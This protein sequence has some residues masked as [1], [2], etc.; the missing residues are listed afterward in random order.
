M[1]F[2]HFLLF[3]ILSVFVSQPV[4]AQTASGTPAF[5]TKA[6]QIYL[7]DAGTGT[8]LFARKEDEAVTSAS[9]AKVMTLA[10]VFKALRDGETSLDTTY[11]VSEN[12]WRTGGAPSRTATMFAALKSQVR[13]EDLVRGVAVQAANDSCL[14]LAEGLSGSETA[15]AAR[16]NKEAKELGL[17]Q[18]NF[19]NSTGLPAPGN[20]TSMRDL[21][22]LAQHLQTTYPEFYRYYS[23][24]EFEWNKIRQR[25]RNPLVGMN[26]GADG[27]VMGFAEDSGYGIVASVSRGGRRLFLAMSGLAN[28][29]ERLDEARRVIDWGMTAFGSKTLFKAG[30][31][32][33]EASVYGG[34]SR[35]VS[36]LSKEDV[37][38]LLPIGNTERLTAR[39]VYSWPVRAPVSPGQAVGVLRI[40]NGE[41]F[42]R[43]V[44][45]HAASAVEVGSLSSRAL[46]ALQE[47]LFFWL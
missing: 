41:Q 45:L 13:L 42:L 25:N 1:S 4:L 34:G 18:S 33:A 38:V 46:D 43:E 17:T 23:E 32:I 40:W 7:V 28:D 3:L 35:H 11:P 44:P 15:F 36:L 21:V 9:L 10:V 47:L 6:K 14:I 24:P 26:I 5:D 37:N 8:I 22:T 39:V 29:K 19:V 31:D 16:M 27:L 30:D 20:H 12:A 2:R